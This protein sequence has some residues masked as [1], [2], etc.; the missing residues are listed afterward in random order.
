MDA[1]FEQ[2]LRTSRPRRLRLSGFP[3]NGSS[4][5]VFVPPTLPGSGQ[6]GQELF[7]DSTSPARGIQ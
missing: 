5:I 4:D 2:R 1:P 6:L 7:D 3:F